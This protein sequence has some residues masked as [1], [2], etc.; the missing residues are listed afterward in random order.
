MRP[1]ARIAWR[2]LRA[3]A[4]PL[5]RASLL[6]L[7]ALFAGVGLLGLAGWFITAAGAAGIAGAGLA[8]NVFRPSAGVRLFAFARTAARYGERLLSHDAVLRSLAALRVSLLASLAAQPFA[9]VA[10]QRVAERLNRLTTDVD[11]LDGVVLRLVIPLASGLATMATVM[12]GLWLMVGA[13][14]ALWLAASYLAGALAAF[15]VVAR[16]SI[17]PSRA[18]HSMLAACRMRTVD[19]LR[20]R[21]ELVLAG[22]LGRRR[23]LADV[24]GER[25]CKARLATDRSERAGA[26]VASIA[27]AVALTGILVLAWKLIGAERI[28]ASL[29]ALG[30]FATLA[31]GEVLM[32]LRRGLA[33]Y[34]KMAD[35]AR[36]IGP[37]LEDA[38]PAD[39]SA[40]GE[41]ASLPTMA[42]GKPV[43]ELRGIGYSYGPAAQ[44]VL[45]NLSLTVSGG[46]TVALTGRSGSGKST[47]LAIAAGVM[48]PGDGRALFAGEPI[49]RIERRCL[50]RLVTLLPQRS[51]LISGTVFENLAMG[52]ADLDEKQAWAV[53]RTVSL[54]PAIAARGG[55][56]SR[57]GEAGNGLSG[58]EQ[59]RLTLARVLLRRPALLLLDEPTEGLDEATARVVLEGARAWLPQAAILLASHRMAERQF[60]DR[61]IAI[62]ASG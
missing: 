25:L 53:L 20:A 3:E 1:L 57:L 39:A 5:A 28:D 50:R 13:P 18:S 10:A 31:L 60:A 15:I 36:R 54:A 42:S 19:L 17:G 8:F 43:L 27:E 2:L 58:G 23:R 41:Q 52:C 48:A 7:T 37:L 61:I 26:L 49:A 16:F 4:W 59:R 51:M 9:E 45:D 40:T 55:L 56:A 46:E 29:A 34:G 44:S 11:A 33:E 22:Q 24:A 21:R 30:F 14:L 6:S 62:G 12:A 35:A 38:E 32:P 47:V